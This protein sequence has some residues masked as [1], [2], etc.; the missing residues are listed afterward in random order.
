MDSLPAELETVIC[1]FLND[2]DSIDFLTSSKRIR[3]RQYT[4]K[5]YVHV[6]YLKESLKDLL[7]S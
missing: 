7:S 6:R 1:N 3:T 5:K 4:A 2:K